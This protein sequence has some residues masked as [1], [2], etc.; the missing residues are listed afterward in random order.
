[1]KYLRRKNSLIP[2][3]VKTLQINVRDIKKEK[4]NDKNCKNMLK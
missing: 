4:S 1:M 2:A 3:I